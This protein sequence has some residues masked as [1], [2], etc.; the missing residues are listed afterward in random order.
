MARLGVTSLAGNRTAQQMR[1]T[2]SR[3]NPEL[4]S[5]ASSS[6]TTSRK[7]FS[8]NV[9]VAVQVTSNVTISDVQRKIQS[10]Q[11]SI[12]RGLQRGY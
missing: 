10:Q 1:D 6:A 4:A 11:I 7:N 8:P 12:G 3:Q 5:I 2:L 9:N